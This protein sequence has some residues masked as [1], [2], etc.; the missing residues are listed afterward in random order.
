LADH[1]LKEQAGKGSEYR[2]D[3]LQAYAAYVTESR[4]FPLAQ[5]RGRHSGASQAIGY[6]K[7]LMFFHMLR[8]ELGDKK[9]VSGLRRFYRD[10]RFTHANFNDFRAAFEAESGG[11]LKQV[12]AQWIDRAGA[13]VLTLAD[14]RF[15]S[16]GLTLTLEQKQR[17]APFDLKVPVILGFT[18]G[19]KLELMVEMKGRRTTV[20]LNTQQKPACVTVDPRF[21]LFR[22]LL[23]GEQPSS[24]GAV[25]GGDRLLIVLPNDAP[26]PLRNAYRQLAESWTAGLAGAEVRVDRELSALPS[27]RSVVLLG[28][29]NRHIKSL[30]QPLIGKEAETVSL[31]RRSWS[32]KNYSFVLTAAHEKRTLAW[33]ATEDPAAVA[34]LA[35]KVPHYGKYSYLVFE[36]A[37]AENKIRGQWPIEN[38]PLA[39]QVG[40]VSC[41]PDPEP[42]LVT[43]NR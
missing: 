9:F 29:R 23:P 17:E 20:T 15:A 21:D 14:A 40:N 43:L 4:D 7:S 2:R 19:R 12:F 16:D 35:R 38:S 37:A 32:R 10:H 1:L 31:E 3:Q 6:G 26:G 25:L 24:V 28:W 41:T 13:P 36:G 33:L 42:P 27:D 34:P 8:R 22:R 39:R 18:D 30:R 5:F 11:N